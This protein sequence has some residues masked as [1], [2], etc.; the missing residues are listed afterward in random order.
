MNPGAA[1]CGAVC[2]TRSD[3]SM[4]FFVLVTC[5]LLLATLFSFPHPLR[6]MPLARPNQVATTVEVSRQAAE[7][8]L[9]SLPVPFQEAGRKREPLA[10]ADESPLRPQE[11]LRDGAVL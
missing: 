11:Q 1:S 10:R 6:S 8:S 7:A 5:Q 4:E 2:Q 3:G 9:P